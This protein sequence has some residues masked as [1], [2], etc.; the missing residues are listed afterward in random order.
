MVGAPWDPSESQFFDDGADVV[1][2]PGALSGEWAFRYRNE[3]EA[4][5]QL[6]D[7]ITVVEIVTVQ[8]ETDI[9]DRQM[10]RID[11]AVVDRLYGSP[12]ENRIA[13]KSPEEAPGHELVVRHERHI[14]GHF[15][16]FSRWFEE[17]GP[18]E[19]AAGHHFHLSPASEATLESVRRRIEI[20]V[21]EEAKAEKED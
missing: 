3:M 9:S 19:S 8:T 4:R 6:S 15:L 18:S 16:L 7:S 14:R 10:K 5:I 2:D 20:R 11:V 13:L 21:E 1:R 12:P 17:P